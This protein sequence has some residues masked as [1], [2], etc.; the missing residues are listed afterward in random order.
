MGFKAPPAAAGVTSLGELGDATTL[1]GAVKLKEGA[2]I[3][4]TRDDPNN[5]LEVAGAAAPVYSAPNLGGKYDFLLDNLPSDAFGLLGPF[6]TAPYTHFLVPVG[7][8][9]LFYPQANINTPVRFLNLLELGEQ[10]LTVAPANIGG[11]MPTEVVDGRYIY[12]PQGF[13][14]S[15]VRGSGFYR[16]DLFT[17]TWTTLA[18][19]TTLN[20]AYRFGY[21]IGTIWDGGDYIYVLGGY[22]TVNNRAVFRYSIS[23]DSWAE[24]TDFPLGGSNTF[25]GSCHLVGG[26]IYAYEATGET[27]YKYNLA[28]DTWTALTGPGVNQAAPGLVQDTV[29]TDNLY[30]IGG[31]GSGWVGRYSISGDSWTALTGANVPGEMQGKGIFIATPSPHILQFRRTTT[32]MWVYKV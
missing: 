31:A 32:Q 4:I 21:F 15:G 22:D 23:G 19:I 10:T 17:N 1:Q 3:T 18:A 24:L 2:N 14:A 27:F 16:Y 7:D 12:V 29:N 26:D 5:A 30:L 6:T 11:S 28:G 13:S 20:A 25:S 8:K 9:S